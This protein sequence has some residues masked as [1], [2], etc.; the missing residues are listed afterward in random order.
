VRVAVEPIDNGSGAVGMVGELRAFA[1]ER[2]VIAATGT[3]VLALLR[4][5]EGPPIGFASPVQVLQSTAERRLEQ[6]AAH[7]LTNLRAANGP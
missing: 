4:L 1:R 7:L 3:Q 6:I 5:W 2:P